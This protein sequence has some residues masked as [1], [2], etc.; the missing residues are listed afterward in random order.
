MKKRTDKELYDATAGGGRY[1]GKSTLMPP[2]GNTFSKVQIKSLV[3]Y[4]R[5]LCKCKGL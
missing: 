5:K 2:W 1:V 3:L 4:L